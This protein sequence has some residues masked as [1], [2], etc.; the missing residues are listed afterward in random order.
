MYCLTCDISIR[1]AEGLIRLTH[2]QSITVS[3]HADRLVD[4]A[5]I[6]L[7]RRIRWRNVDK[8]PIRRG[9]EVSI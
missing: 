4:T 5:T 9:N 3:K 6:V 2:A 7:P 1:T 8:N